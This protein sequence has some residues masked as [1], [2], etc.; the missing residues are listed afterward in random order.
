MLRGLTASLTDS[1]LHNGTIDPAAVARSFGVEVPG[2]PML[3]SEIPSKSLSDTPSTIQLDT[4]ASKPAPKSSLLALA[5]VRLHSLRP[6][7]EERKR[8]VAAM[9]ALMV[10]HL[11]AADDLIATIED[12]HFAA[13]EAR[14]ERI[15]KA[16]REI[17]DGLPALQRAQAEA[18]MFGN[19]SEA[20]KV[21][22]KTKLENAYEARKRISRWATAAEIAA[23]DKTLAKARV[24]MN[25][26]TEMALQKQRD[27]VDC[28]N[29]VKQAEANLEALG[30]EKE[31]LDAEL[32][33]QPYF[34]PELGLST[35]PVFYRDSW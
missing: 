22:A 27:L 33:G 13:I 17:L 23:A 6:Q 19:N 25:R 12:E 1:R 32:D 24:E 11:G 3:E 26:A 7:T 14:K 10:E 20:A 16:G 5:Q 34:H 15:R 30:T 18:R 2:Q 21:A 4:R 35:S 29:Q 31:R 8:E 9:L 28:E